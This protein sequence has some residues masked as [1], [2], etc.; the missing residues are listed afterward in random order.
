VI[1]INLH[2][3]R[4]G[5]GQGPFST[6][7]IMSKLGQAVDKEKFYGTI[8]MKCENGKLVY[9]TLEQRFTVDNLLKLLNS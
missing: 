9:C 7:E 2:S 1:E 8:I 3:I 5:I 4:Q 6:S